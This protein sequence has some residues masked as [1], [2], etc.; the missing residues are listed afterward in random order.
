MRA[1][2]E[3]V[4]RALKIARGQIDGVLRMIDDDRYCVE[5]ANQLLATEAILK[6]VNQEI[7][8]AH[9]RGCVAEALC[10]REPQP[11]L[12]EALSLLE[13]MASR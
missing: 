3:R 11:E 5:I 1:D 2:R 12:E 13:K 4:T 8:Q 10:T 7:L 6:K 9:I